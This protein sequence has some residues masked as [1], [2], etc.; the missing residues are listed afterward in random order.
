ME[1]KNTRIYIR[2]DETFKASLEEFCHKQDISVSDF[3]RLA[4]YEVMGKE[5]DIA[6]RLMQ[7]RIDMHKERLELLRKIRGTT[8]ERTINIK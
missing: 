8:G 5:K 7:A 1:S 2:T 4:A 6:E 3:L